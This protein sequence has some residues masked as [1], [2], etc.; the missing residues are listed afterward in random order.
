MADDVVGYKLL[1]SYDVRPELI[2]E[3]RQFVLGVYIPF[4][5]SK[6]LQISQAWHTAYGEAPN[7]MLE[8]VCREH[9]VVE[10]LFRDDGWFAFNEKLETFV[11]DFVYKVIPYKDGFQI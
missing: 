1:V 8:F 7:R 3:Y 10:S 4:M 11:E 5:G 2:N 9:D 6:G